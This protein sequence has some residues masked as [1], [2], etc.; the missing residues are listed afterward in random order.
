MGSLMGRPSQPN[1]DRSSHGAPRSAPP[2]GSP[3][4]SV[5]TYRIRAATGRDADAIFHLLYNPPDPHLFARTRLEVAEM[6]DQSDMYVVEADGALIATCA[7]SPPT[8]PEPGV[9]APAGV[10][11]EFGGV[12]V[13][14]DH[15][16]LGLAKMLAVLAL[17]DYRVIHGTAD[18]LLSHVL[19][20]NPD[21]RPLLEKLGFTLAD[22]DRSH[23][24]NPLEIPGLAH[25]P[26]DPEGAVRADILR[27]PET[28]YRACLEAAL[29][30]P[31][32]VGD[33]QR[34]SSVL[35]VTIRSFRTGAMQQVLHELS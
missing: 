1:N 16:G 21:P 12:Y 30:T 19:V 31:S 35:E 6:L 29:A 26:R 2:G 20:Q 10:P 7:I 13:H 25:M 18:P 15:R 5:S 23:G 3:A 9:G 11:S 8:A 4:T 24:Y 17:A 14:P 22:A 27:F 28:G 32:A 33:A 34:G